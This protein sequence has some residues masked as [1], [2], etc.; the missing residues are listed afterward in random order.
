MAT[1][2][3]AIELNVKISAAKPHQRPMG[4]QRIRQNISDH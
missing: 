2:T 1:A 4:Q 3:T